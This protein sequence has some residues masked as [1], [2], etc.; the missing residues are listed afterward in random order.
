M[1]IQQHL[2][3]PSIPQTGPIATC[4]ACGYT[5]YTLLFEETTMK[6]AQCYITIYDPLNTAT[7]E[8]S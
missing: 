3:D 7:D 1:G 2:F 4:P 6:C 8:N 5:G